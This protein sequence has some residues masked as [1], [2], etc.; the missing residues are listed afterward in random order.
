MNRFVT[1]SRALLISVCLAA[2]AGWA[3]LAIFY[4]NLP[5]ELHL[6]AA[7]LFGAMG[8]VLAILGGSNRRARRILLAVFMAVLIW[9]LT[10][11]PS[12][13]RDWQP[14]VAILPYA[15]IAGDRVTIHNIRNC[16][17]RSETDYT[18]RYYDKS[19]DLDRLTTADLFL[20]Y[21]GSPTYCPHH[22]QFRLR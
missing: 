2:M 5:P 22:A 16:D 11:P 7:V 15:D 10:I 4:S 6:A 3:T 21:W 9:W 13:N 17:Y 14:D 12:N 20:V 8:L 19:F 18:C 1:F